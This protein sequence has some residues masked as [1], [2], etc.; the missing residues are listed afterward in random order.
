LSA[1]CASIQRFALSCFL[2]FCAL[3]GVGEVQAVQPTFYTT[4]SDFDNPWR[5]AGV[6]K[7]TQPGGALST[8][9]NQTFDTLNR[10]LSMLF[11]IKNTALAWPRSAR[12]LRSASIK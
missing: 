7:T 8:T 12:W 1:P 10:W 2:L 4:L 9:I 6:T 3:L 11:S 5:M